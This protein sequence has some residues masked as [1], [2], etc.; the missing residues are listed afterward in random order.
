M[1]QKDII[2]SKVN[3]SKKGSIF[4]PDSFLPID[5][6]YVSNVL[7]QLVKDGVLVRISQ[8]IYLKPQMTRF[9]PLM[10]SL[11]QVAQAI[12]KRDHAKILPYGPVAE[13]YLG[14]STQVPMNAVYITSGASRKLRIGN[15]TLTLKYAVPTNFSF[16][17]KV[18]PILVLALKSIGKNNVTEDTLDTVYGVLKENPEEETWQEDIKLAPI[19]IRKIIINTK[20]RIKNNEQVD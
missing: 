11:D 20:N 10:P 4:L 14:F 6:Q 2:I 19:W 8:G 17:G 13:N 1:G 3:R 5:V 18:M 12:A 7:G 9:G 16:K 15:R